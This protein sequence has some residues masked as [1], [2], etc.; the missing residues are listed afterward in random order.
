[1]SEQKRKSK[2][3]IILFS[4][5]FGLVF[6]VV[7]GLWVSDTDTV[8]ETPEELRQKIQNSMNKNYSVESSD[9]VS[10]N[11]TWIARSEQRFSSMERENQ[12]LKSLLE[13]MNQKLDYMESERSK[14]GQQSSYSDE[15]EKVAVEGIIVPPILP[16]GS[17]DEEKYPSLPPLPSGGSVNPVAGSSSLNPNSGYYAQPI[18]VVPQQAQIRAIK[19][20]DFSDPASN[21]PGEDVSKNVTNYIPAGAFSTVVLLS[22]LDAPTGGQAMSNPVPVL[23]RVMDMGQLPNYFN[24]G[25]QDCHMIGAGY[26]ELSSERANIRLEKMSCVLKNGNVVEATLNGY[27]AGEDGKAGLRGRL[28]SKQGSVI[29]KALLAGMASGMGESINSQYSNISTSALGSVQTLES[30]K[31]FQSGLARGASNALEKIADF[32]IAR[33]NEMY[34]IIEVDANRIGEAILTTG[35]KLEFNL[36]GTTRTGLYD[37]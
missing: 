4:F 6:L 27:V 18:E 12:E 14:F 7:F 15:N 17:I 34:P 33:A 2:Q 24:S 30:N 16:K 35:S 36:I 21:K 3:K 29:A 23:L 19:V 5:I 10:D 13:R 26:G 1:M 25:I 11:E 9:V 32:Y 37:E 8:R 22:G 20:Y 31:V 28:V